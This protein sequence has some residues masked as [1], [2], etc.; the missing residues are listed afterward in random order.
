V[1][2]SPRAS[3]G[4]SECHERLKLG[5]RLS[6]AAITLLAAVPVSSVTAQGYNFPD[7]RALILNTCPFV[8]LSQFAFHNQYHEGGTRFEQDL[9]WK[10]VGKQPIVAFEVVV[11]KYDAFDRRLVGTR[12]TITGRNSG[13]WT[14]LAPGASDKDG[15]IGYGTEETYTAIAYVRSARLSDG[16][17]WNVADADL[18]TQLRKVAPA[19]KEFGDVRPD[20]KPLP[21]K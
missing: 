15:T 2:W 13:D 6:Y 5:K 9:T 3:R 18:V 16:S 8:S 4:I 21:T 11:L 17:V 10:N 20:P 12:W 14:P 19:I 1:L 7:R